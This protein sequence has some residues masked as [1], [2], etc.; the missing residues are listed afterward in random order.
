MR[1]WVLRA[2]VSL[3]GGRC[4]ACPLRL[5]SCTSIRTRTE[6]AI[7]ADRVVVVASLVPKRSLS[8]A[9]SEQCYFNA[10]PHD[11]SISVCMRLK[12]KSKC[13]WTSY[14][15]ENGLA[16]SYIYLVIVSIYNMSSVHVHNVAYG[17]VKHHIPTATTATKLLLIVA[18]VRLA[19]AANIKSTSNSKNREP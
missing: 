11:P 18:I 1:M 17:K 5:W 4:I 10:A 12:I 19:R 15:S 2:C 13:I 7:F 8:L 9:Y 14:A 3:A 6:S 16:A